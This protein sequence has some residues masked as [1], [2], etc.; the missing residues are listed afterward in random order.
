M[1]T[2]KT[3]AQIAEKAHLEMEARESLY[4]AKQL[5]RIKTRTNNIT[6]E[7]GRDL[8]NNGFQVEPEDPCQVGMG[9]LSTDEYTPEELVE[10]A[11]P[12]EPLLVD[13]DMYS[14]P[15]PARWS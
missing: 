7:L 6:A 9:E 13:W 10:M 5:K 1:A 8:E 11:Q 14:S 4:R 12:H 3:F 2:Y 15:N